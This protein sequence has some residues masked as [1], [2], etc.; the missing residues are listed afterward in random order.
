MLHGPALYTQRERL[1]FTS[2]RAAHGWACASAYL[3][4]MIACY[5]L[6]LLNELEIA[7]E[8][9]LRAR[10]KKCPPCTYSSIKL[11]KIIVEIHLCAMQNGSSRVASRHA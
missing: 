1:D 11:D 7:R 4:V 2:K 5:R 6:S 8:F 9:G 3:D 10:L